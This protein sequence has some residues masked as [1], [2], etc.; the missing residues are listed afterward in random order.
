M[1][2]LEGAMSSLILFLIGMFVG[3]FWLVHWAVKRESGE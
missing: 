3:L 2:K 1:D